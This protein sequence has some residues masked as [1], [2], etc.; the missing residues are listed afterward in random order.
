MTWTMHHMNDISTTELLT[1]Q[2]MSAADQAAVASGVPSLELMENAGRAVA[3]V[4]ERLVAPKARIIIA[5]GPGNNGGDGFVAARH[6]Q[7]RGFRVDVGLLGSVEQLR[8]DAGEMANAWQGQT[9]D[10]DHLDL[11]TADLLIDALFGAGLTRPLD[12]SAATLVAGLNAAP[13]PILS[14]DVPSGLDGSTGQAQGPVISA[15]ATISFFRPKPGHLLL[16]GRALCGDLHI[17]D[18][19]IPD[20]V[21]EQLDITTFRN[22]PPVWQSHWQP[23]RIHGHKYT[24]GHAV[25][26]SGPVHATGAAR[27][28]AI[29]AQRAGAGLV[30][31]ASP[32][33]A[34]S[35]NAAH[36]TSIM[37]APLDGHRELTDVLAD[38]RYNSVVIGPG[39]GLTDKTLARVM[40]ALN[41]SAAVVLDAD[42]LTLSARDRESVFRAIHERS[43]PAVLTPHEG[44]FRRLFPNTTGDKLQR[45]R[46]AASESGAVVVLKGADTVIAAPDGSAAIND[47]APPWLATAGAGDVLA[48]FIAGILAQSVP[49]W[50]AAC[51]AV[52]L[53]GAC[54]AAHG[55]GMIAEDLTEASPGVLRALS[56]PCCPP[57][58]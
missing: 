37:I 13:A 22:A 14:V 15:R 3:D 21:L 58:T 7:A 42:A 40:G 35:V 24:R 16:P 48:G 34:V 53:H 29:G 8:G 18:I 5:C 28:A 2:Q 38:P 10:C 11:G 6:L 20:L 32:E 41:T 17:A 25:V 4:A 56:G 31:I 39:A 12:G 52:W 46:H 54:A 30:T 51:M 57:A 26:L 55:P 23:P 19:G 47:N 44:E 27:L 43:S 9:A 45:A 33:D 50:P 49:A 1:N 36:L